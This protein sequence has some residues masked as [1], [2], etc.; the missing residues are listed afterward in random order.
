MTNQ[1]AGWYADPSGDPTKLRY[2]DG[3]Q[4]T[5]D[6]ADAQP[7]VAPATPYDASAYGQQPIGQQPTGQPTDYTY[8]NQGYAQ[9]PTSAPTYYQP[10][11][12]NSNDATLRMVAFVF[13]I[14]SLVASCWLIVPLAWMIPMTVHTWGIYKGTKPN[15][16]AFGVCTL[17]FTSLVGGILLLVSKKDQ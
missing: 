13:C 15:T 9:Q 8:P 2:W 5:N 4:W 10:S 3:T 6:Y 17:L 12:V 14:I 11:T 7:P 1:Q 16:T